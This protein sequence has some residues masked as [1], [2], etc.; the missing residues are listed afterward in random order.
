MCIC[1]VY[2]H[3]PKQVGLPDEM[4]RTFTDLRGAHTGVK[5]PVRKHAAATP[6]PEGRGAKPEGGATEEFATAQALQMLQA[7]VDLLAR[8]VEGTAT[9]ASGTAPGSAAPLG[10]IR[11]TFAEFDTNHDNDLSSCELS[12][13]LH[14]LGLEANDWAPLLELSAS[15]MR[16]C[17]YARHL[18]TAT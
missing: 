1:T 2:V 12:E 9:A 7:K 13:A 15:S 10:A 8:S 6:Q 18:D 5:Q 17:S 16:R 11:N 3:V 4:R 14:A